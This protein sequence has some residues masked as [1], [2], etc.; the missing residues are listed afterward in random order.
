MQQIVY[1]REKKVIYKPKPFRT[2]FVY[3]LARV[4]LSHVSRIIFNVILSCIVTIILNEMP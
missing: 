1:Y 4:A 3:A 2:W